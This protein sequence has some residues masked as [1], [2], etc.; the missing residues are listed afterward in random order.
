MRTST[1]SRTGTSTTTR[2]S[3]SSPAYVRT[4]AKTVIMG[5]GVTVD[6]PC[7]GARRGLLPRPLRL[8]TMGAPRPARH[9]RALLDELPAARLLVAGDPRRAG[10]LNQVLM[11]LGVIAEPSRVCSSTTT[12]ASSSSW[13]TSTPVRRAGPVRLARAVRLH[14]ADGGAGPRRAPVAGV[15]LCPAAADPA[16]PHHGLRSSCSSRS[17]ANS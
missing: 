4:L 16:R 8:A 11:S 3:S 1:S 10:A 12:S 6:L 5:A 14:P 17:S 9:H 13:C 2:S 15:R 7:R